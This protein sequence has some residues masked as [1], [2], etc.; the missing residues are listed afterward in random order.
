MACSEMLSLNKRERRHENRASRFNPMT[1]H[2]VFILIGAGG[3]GEKNTRQEM[4]VSVEERAKLPVLFRQDTPLE[5]ST[6]LAASWAGSDMFYP[7]GGVEAPLQIWVER[8]ELVSLF[9]PTGVP[10]CQGS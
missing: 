8:R 5:T 9:G 10:V 3:G 2:P 1:S 7:A 6:F 4:V